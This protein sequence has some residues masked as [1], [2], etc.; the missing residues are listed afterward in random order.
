MSAR[1][2][3]HVQP[4]GRVYGVVVGVRRADGRWLMVRR[5]SA[6][7]IPNKVCFPGGAME[8]G[9][10]EEQACIREAREELGVVV[11]PVR[12]VWRHDFED[13]PLTLFGWLAE[14]QEGAIRADPVE[15]AEVLWLSSEEGSCHPDGLVT[16]RGF[17]AALEAAGN[18]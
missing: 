4:D 13:K 9:E 2:A 11:R 8:Q 5:G 10:T 14:V 12:R 6:V 18:P 3:R 15:I 16:N 1:P 7:A 17:I